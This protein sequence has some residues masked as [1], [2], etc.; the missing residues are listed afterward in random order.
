[1]AVVHHDVGVPLKDVW[2]QIADPYAYALWVVGAAAIR[3]VDGPWPEPGSTFHHT[4]G[5][6]R[7]GLRDTSSVVEAQPPRR[8][9]LEVRARPFVVARVEI[10]LEEREGGTR[11][12]MDETVRGGIFGVLGP[13]NAPALLLRNDEALRRLAA[14][15]WAR[16]AAR[17][18][19]ADRAAAVA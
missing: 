8:I 1:V 19:G 5:H 2:A 12:T 11:I 7:L 18:T 14:M 6:A 4:Q 16:H 17:T 10:V 15:A 9:V 3:D 13:L